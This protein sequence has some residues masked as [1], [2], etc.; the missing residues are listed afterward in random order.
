MRFD[1]NLGWILMIAL[2]I[3]AMAWTGAWAEDEAGEPPP[4]K[5]SAVEGE[6]AVSAGETESAVDIREVL[7]EP[8]EV[9]PGVP[10]GLETPARCYAT[11]I[12]ARARV[13]A[14]EIGAVADSTECLDLSEVSQLVRNEHGE[15]VARQLA[16]ILAT[17]QESLDIEA[18]V[19]VPEGPGATI[20]SH[21]EGD[22]EIARSEDGGWRFSPST[23]AA[24]PEIHHE[25]EVSGFFEM[26][27]SMGEVDEELVA[28]GAVEE[29]GIE[30]W[31]PASW[32]NRTFL[33]EDWQWLYLVL[34]ILIGLV[35]DRL[36]PIVVRQSLIFWLRNTHLRDRR[37]LAQSTS[38]PFGF[39]AMS[40]FWWFVLGT[41]EFE[42]RV[43]VILLTAVK[44]M[45]AAGIV[46]CAYRA[47]DVA[48]EFI[49]YRAEK[50]ESR[51][52][53]LLVPFVRKS[54][55]VVV[56]VFGVIFVAS[57]IDIN[58]SSL[59]AGLGIGGIA[60]ALAAKD[61]LENLFGS[62]TVL[63]DRPFQV[64]DWVVIGGVEGTVEELGFRS[65]RIRTF[66][67]SVI[68]VPNSKLISTEVDNYGAREFRR[69]KTMLSV[70]YNT[71][72]DKIEAFCEGIRELLRNHPYARKDYFHVWLNEFS[73][74]S[75]DVLLYCFL[76]TPDWGTELRERHRLFLDI[77][78]LAQE[79]GIEF[80]FPTQTIFMGK[81]AEPSPVFPDEGMIEDAV[82]KEKMEARKR[83]EDIALSSLGGKNVIPPPVKFGDRWADDGLGDGQ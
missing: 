53:D 69:I 33:L 21:P 80:A 35:I 40:V 61:T 67:N 48:S 79:L 1:R 51:M 73:S 17:N 38:R 74:S 42:L 39:L 62:I 46:W 14:G 83:A 41:G 59:L 58:V 68:T 20:Y 23:V 37:E 2:A 34:I 65:T 12:D 60:I 29:F 30:N 26:K 54:L 6:D 31:I 32:K 82:A 16:R 24:I 9:E 25:L 10:E 44:F 45:T 50:T 57:N 49:E 27:E 7:Q 76:R 4:G 3:G 77:L 81:E 56:A 13:R 11:F 8:V 78:R 47:V 75:L 71:P 63:F 18:L 55:K 52:D 22:I 43:L 72:P 70:T 28:A 5:P 36:I 66:Y 64:G 19:D 15:T